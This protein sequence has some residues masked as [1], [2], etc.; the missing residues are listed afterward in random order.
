M[1][2]RILHA[3]PLFR[4]EKPEPLGNSVNCYASP[5]PAIE[6]DRV[7]VHFGS[8]GTACLDAITGETVT[9][10]MTDDE[11][12]ELVATGWTPEPVEDNQ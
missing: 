9:R 3:L 7:Y 5:S 12:A 6:K 2:G 8:Y 4:C 11:Y 1:S 10:E